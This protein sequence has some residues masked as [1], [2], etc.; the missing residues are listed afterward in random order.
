MNS[1]YEFNGL[2]AS[3]YGKCVCALESMHFGNRILIDDDGKPAPKN[4]TPDAGYTVSGSAWFFYVHLFRFLNPELT[5]D[6]IE[7]TLLDDQGQQPVNDNEIQSVMEDTKEV[8]R[9]LLR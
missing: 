1:E 5:P 9:L 6:E 3:F 8:L 4:R 7:G 2:P